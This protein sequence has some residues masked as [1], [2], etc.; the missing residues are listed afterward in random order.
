MPS[1]MV[2]TVLHSYMLSLMPGI[3]EVEIQAVFSQARGLNYAVSALAFALTFL[4]FR[5]WSISQGIQNADTAF[6]KPAP[7]A[8]RQKKALYVFIGT[9]CVLFLPNVLVA[10][11]GS[12]TLRTIAGKL[13]L[14]LVFFSA[15]LVCMV[16]KLGDTATIIRE[17]VP[18][19]ICIMLFGVAGLFQCLQGF[20]LSDVLSDLFRRSVPPLVL[21]LVCLVVAGL[22]AMISDGLSVVVPLMFP[23]I[24]S[25]SAA[26]ETPLALLFYVVTT[27][28]V[29]LSFA[30]LCSTGALTIGVFPPEKQE[31]C[32]PR[33]W[34]LAFLN[35][36]VYAITI[37]VLYP[38]FFCP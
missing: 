7:L 34:K 2:G 27:P 33:L 19:N 29:I 17:R 32:Q 20:G 16:L 3:T 24:W 37:S 12:G 26:T 25:L 35:L 21:A 6:C 22:I 4:C 1:G 13:D 30:P 11:T 18:W 14:V 28:V 31:H 8:P 15:A 38:I 23:I 36:A 9:V 10:V 5:G